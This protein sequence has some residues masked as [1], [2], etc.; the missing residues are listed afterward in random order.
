MFGESIYNDALDVLHQVD[1]AL[2]E[3]VY[4]TLGSNKEKG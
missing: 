3:E 1:V 2:V 4:P